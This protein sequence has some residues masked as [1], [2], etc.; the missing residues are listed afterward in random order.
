MTL[1]LLTPRIHVKQINNFSTLYFELNIFSIK[2]VSAVW[3]T[4]NSTLKVERVPTLELILFNF[5]F[6]F[7]FG[8]DED[9]TEFINKKYKQE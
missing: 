2:Y 4:I 3:K 7:Y 8:K 1:K 6:I 5:N 9:W